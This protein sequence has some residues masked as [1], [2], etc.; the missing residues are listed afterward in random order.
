[1]VLLPRFDGEAAID[2]MVREDVNVF[3][4]V[5]TMYIGAARPRP[6]RDRR[7]PTAAAVRVRRRLA[8]PSRC[9]D[10]FDERFG[11]TSTRGT[12]CPRPRPSATT[13]QPHF[14]TRGRHRRPPD[15]GRRGRD[16]PAR[17]RG[18][19]RAARRRRARR[20]RDP[21]AQRVRRVPRP[22][23]RPPPQALVDGWFRT[24]DLGTKDADG[25]L[26]H[27]RPQEGHCHPRRVQRLPPRGR[28]GARPAPGGRP[29]RGDRRPRRTARRG[30]LRGRG[31]SP[32]GRRP[33]PRQELIDWSGST[34]AGTSTRAGSEFVEALPLG[35]SLKVLKR[36]L[37]KDL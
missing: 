30:D 24:G 23:R 35:P 3:H 13:N 36:E 28:G 26:S 27:R 11:T 31:P 10:R 34:S 19:D 2:L 33:R 15:L 14:G 7:L 37:I 9:C 21:R 17:G 12:G 8:C 5:P 32:A 29:G 22:T 18:P 1:M 6:R 25:F 20:D 16:R 4:G